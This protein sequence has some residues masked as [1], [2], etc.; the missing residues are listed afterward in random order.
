MKKVKEEKSEGFFEE[1]PI[2]EKVWQMK[3]GYDEYLAQA[4]NNIDTKLFL[5]YLR[6]CIRRN[7]VINLSMRGRVRSGKSLSSLSVAVTISKF[8]GIPFIPSLHVKFSWQ[9]YM[10][11]LQ[12]GKP[13][14]M[15]SVYVIDEK[16]EEGGMGSFAEQQAQ[17]NVQ[18]ICA[19]K[20]IHTISLVGDY[21]ILNINSVYNLVTRERN[22]ESFET[23]LILY[24]VENQEEIP[25]C[26]VVI[27]IKQI[28]C[29]T[30]LNHEKNPEGKEISGCVLCHKYNDDK[31][32][33]M[34]T[35]LKQYEKAKD[36]NIDR[37]T[38]GGSPS[39]RQR[40]REECAIKLLEDKS[41]FTAHSKE[42][43]KALANALLPKMIN[44]QFTMDEV[45]EI[46]VLSRIYKRH[47]EERGQVPKATT[48]LM[49]FDEKK[50]EKKHGK[51]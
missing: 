43:M 12:S 13:I 26:S 20:C 41:Y 11:E 50:T 7:E 4:D 9:D 6:H 28:L 23:R 30:I 1:E 18:R 35:F 33:P 38:K 14:P 21:S 39:A 37:I 45:D 32:C 46:V 49:S 19:K 5:S 22:F 51:Q 36:A 3:I 15:H 10:N 8:T 16:E 31:A 2:K 42:E 27:P 47:M 25:V 40:A 24:N 44:R 29:D 34:S 17:M 48:N